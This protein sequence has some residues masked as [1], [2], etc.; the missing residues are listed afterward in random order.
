MGGATY[1]S[2]KEGIGYSFIKPQRMG[3]VLRVGVL[4]SDYVLCIAPS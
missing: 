2:A 4:S 1:K 3:S